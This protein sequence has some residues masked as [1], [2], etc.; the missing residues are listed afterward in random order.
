MVVVLNMPLSTETF[1]GLTIRDMRHVQALLI[2][3]GFALVM[4]MLSLAALFAGVPVRRILNSAVVCVCFDGD[5]CEIT[6]DPPPPTSRLSI[7]SKECVP[8]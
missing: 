7:L 4:M 1:A 2:H 8:S 5:G 6:F 3:H